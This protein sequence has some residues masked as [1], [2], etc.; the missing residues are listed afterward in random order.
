MLLPNTDFDPTESA[1]PWQILT[2]A[3]HEVFFATQDGSIAQCDKITLTGDGLT[4]MLGSLAIR[5]ANKRVY[6]EMSKDTHFN[7]P[8]S[9]QNV[10]PQDFDGLLLPGGHAKGMKPYLESEHVFSICRHFF[11]RKAP[12]GSVCHG[13]LAL[14]R[15][16]DESG[17]SILHGYR[18]TGLNNFQEKIALRLTQKTMGLHYQTYIQTVQDEVSSVLARKKDFKTGPFLPVFGT[19][20]SP[21]KGF[22]VVDRNLVSARWPGDVYKFSYAYLSLID[23]KKSA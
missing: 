21:Q 17:Q 8:F 4:G 1:I 12:V 10:S 23:V 5:P 16:L 7:S 6:D 19:K 14:A 15:T 2:Q 3:G 20:K 11:A 9:W 18:V 13:V 22:V